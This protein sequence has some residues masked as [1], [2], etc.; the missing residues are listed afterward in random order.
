MPYPRTL[1]ERRGW[2]F[3]FCVALVEPLLR[4][5]T[6]RRWIDGTKIPARGGCVIA[7]NHVSHL[8]PF[9]F[10]HFV[11]GH[12]RIVRFLAKAEV[13]SIPVAGRIVRSAGQIPVYRLTNDAS[14]A[15]RAA[16][17]SV[18]R[19]ECVVVYPEGTI[20]REP[21]LWPMTGRTGAARI[22]LASGVPVIPVAQWGPQEILAP[23]AKRPH[24][25][26]RKLVTVKAGDPVDLTEFEGRELTPDV[27]RQATERIMDA[28]THQLEDIRGEKAPAERFDARS[29][30]V[31]EIGN[32]N[33]QQ[34]R[35]RRKEGRR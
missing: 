11:Y 3:A 19:G 25:F 4:A 29:R 35:R 16:V 8:D 6:R 27:L 30:G 12:G 18:R 33:G 15:F 34:R 24:L 1:Q 22:A 28:I 7:V 5:L 26:P 23:Y 32:P 13:F 21:D 31:R 20:T 10:A 9:T 17:A 14:Q 2:A